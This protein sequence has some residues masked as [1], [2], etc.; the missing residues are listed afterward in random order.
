MQEYNPYDLVIVDQTKVDLYFH[1]IMTQTGVTHMW[2]GAAYE[3]TPHHEWV[4]D[5]E[6]FCILKKLV[7]FKKYLL[8]QVGRRL[9]RLRRV[10]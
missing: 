9:R 4:R 5:S 8:F 10:V 6:I 3:L 7:M 1:Y 2:G